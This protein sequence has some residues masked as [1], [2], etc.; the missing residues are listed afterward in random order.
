MSN[1]LFKTLARILMGCLIGYVLGKAL[2]AQVPAAPKSNDLTS[3]QKLQYQNL[4]QAVQIQQLQYQL[5]RDRFEQQFMMV[6]QVKQVINEL[7]KAAKGVDDFV[8]KVLAEKG[9][10]KSKYTLDKDGKV[11]EI[12]PEV[13]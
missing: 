11:T 10:D 1:K 7:D 4:Q 3:E 12:K 8:G 2:H 6:P 5:L 9:L 13:K